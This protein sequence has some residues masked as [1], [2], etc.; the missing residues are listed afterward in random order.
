MNQ[1]NSWVDVLRGLAIL[2]VVAVHCI[3]QTNEFIEQSV[4]SNSFSSFISLGKYG[5]ELFFFL[6]GWLLG[7][8]YGFASTALSKTYWVKRVA[9]IY[10]LW[11]VF[12]LVSI[13]RY[14]ITET[15][16]FHSALTTFEVSSSL[17][18]ESLMI[19]FFTLTFTLFLFGPL[20]NTVIPGGWSIQAEI[21]HY[22]LFPVIRRTSTSLILKILTVINF[23]TILAVAFRPKMETIP[24]PLL[25]IL[26]AWLRL[27][28][29]S[30]IGYF[31]IGVFAYR[32]IFQIN[33]STGTIELPSGDVPGLSIAIFFLSFLF[34]PC[35][36]GSQIEA[37][38]YVAFML[39]IS[40]SI[41]RIDFFKS[42]FKYLGRHS[43]F[44][45]FVHFLVLDA[46][47]FF[48]GEINFRSSDF[49]SQQILFF[50]IL[51]FTMGFS[52]L[53]SIPSMKYFELPIMRMAQKIK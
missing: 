39:L 25:L 15:G 16:G 29:Y 23:F 35:P 10:P 45:Y 19:I 48:L 53:A 37:I 49:G 18:D 8:I 12:L 30:T 3:P 34:V 13:I 33:K 31:L 40:F 44:I 17:I 43:Y 38:T 2:G 28:L 4:Q 26:D 46:I 24:K 5:V 9:R 42:V 32:L 22:L 27:G 14:S 6:S 52:L 7:S 47:A 11:I 36:F 41:M 1:R 51:F 21:A 50:G 20:W